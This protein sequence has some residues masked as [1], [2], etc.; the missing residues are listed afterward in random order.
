MQ[1]VSVKHWGLKNDDLFTVKGVHV[2]VPKPSREHLVTVKTGAWKSD[3]PRSPQ[4]QPIFSPVVLAEPSRDSVASSVLTG[5]TKST[6]TAQSSVDSSTSTVP[7]AATA[8]P[9]FTGRIKLTAA[10]QTK[11]RKSRWE[12][13]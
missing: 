11:E 6:I 3:A 8:V 10:L 9:T 5:P 7:A 1:V 13:S 4:H 12:S 2:H